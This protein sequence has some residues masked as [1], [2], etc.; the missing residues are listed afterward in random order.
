MG[1]DSQAVPASPSRSWAIV[2]FAA[3]VFTAALTFY[4]LRPPIP[5]PMD[6]PATEF[7]ACRAIQHGYA[8][9]KEP[10]PAGSPANDKVEAYILEAMKSLGIDTELVSDVHVKGHTA[11]RR[12][13]VLGRIPGTAN[14]KAFALMAHYDSTAYGP[15][16]ADDG[17]GV[18]SMLETARALKASPPLKNDV[19]FAFTDGEEGP[20]LGSTLFADGPWFQETGVLA[21]LEARGTQGNSLLFGT[22]PSNGW[23]IEQ[24][25]QGVRYPTMSS[26]MYGVYQRLPFSSDFD[27][28]RPLGMKGF[29]IAFIDNFAWYHTTN[30]RPE[31]LDLGTLQQHGMYALDLARHFG[32]IP[33]DGEL[34]APDAVYFNTLGYH[35]ACYPMVWNGPLVLGTLLLTVLAWVVGFVRKHLSLSG[36][37]I[38]IMA[39]PVAA[40]GAAAIGVGMVAALWG[41]PTA[42]DLYAHGITRIPDLY[43]LYH[44]DLYV[45]ALAAAAVSVVALVYGG[46]FRRFR[47][48]DLAA[49]TF[50]WWTVG[51]FVLD[52]FMPGAGYLLMWPLAFAALGML[53][54]FLMSKP[55]P[56]APGW[57]VF[58]TPFI[59]PAIVLALPTYRVFGYAILIMGGP[60]LAAYLA[61]NLGLMAPQ[62]DLMARVN[63]W[64]L[65]LSSAALAAALFSIG[66]VNSG[67]TPLRPKLDSVS[68]GIDHDAQR[69]YWLSPDP[70][71]DEWTSQFFP[72]NTAR[73]SCPE[74]AL[75][76]REKVLKA[77]APIAGGYPG[78]KIEVKSDTTAGSVR[79]V[80]FHVSSPAQAAQLTLRWVSGGELLG[81]SMAGKPLDTDKGKWRLDFRVFP[82]EGVDITLCVSAGTPVKINLL[83]TFYGLPELPGYRPRPDYIIATPNTVNHHR[84][85]IESNRFFVV[86]TVEL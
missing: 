85:T 43:P 7:S 78:A 79:D 39:W 76:G 49:G 36:F 53:L 48:Q 2:V 10:H 16:A 32:D 58:L 38:G 57:I 20:K 44:N 61:L 55:G 19:I 46:L 63:R 42:H 37:S 56:L 51:L 27:V 41:W 67:F 11:F 81:A 5:L 25:I 31:H 33:L 15:G 24:A 70:A 18:M 60:G 47:A 9:A 40:G 28:L 86:R 13:L 26:L 34:T 29:D 14:T 45:W 64:W 65:P 62:F 3:L 80:T 84:K 1:N 73:E 6:A 72:A 59:L 23:L 22:S 8:F 17:G 66:Y 4:L 68:Y 83:E 35:M 50:V 71:P 77:A 82:K 54:C 69:A 74:F 52:L 75:G 21:N 12:H 30:D